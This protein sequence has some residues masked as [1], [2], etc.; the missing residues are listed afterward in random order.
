MVANVLILSLL[1][2]LLFDIFTIIKNL[3]LLFFVIFF[4]VVWS[5]RLHNHHFLFWSSNCLC[6]GQWDPYSGWL[7]C[8]FDLSCLSLSILL[9][10]GTARCSRFILQFLCSPRSGHF[11]KSL[12]CSLRRIAFRNGN[13]GDGRAHYYRYVGSPRPSCWTVLEMAYP[14]T[15]TPMFFSIS[16]HILNE[17]T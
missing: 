4:I 13:L 2:Y 1:L 15:F 5:H 8:P 12:G 9:L 3:F 11:P 6:F 7:L 14:H 10:S 17:F 16:S